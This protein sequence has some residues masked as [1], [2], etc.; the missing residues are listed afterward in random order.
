MP[1][2]CAHGDPDLAEMLA[3]PRVLDVLGP[4][5]AH[6]GKRPVKGAD[7][8]GDRDV[9]GVAVEAVGMGVGE[10]VGAASAWLVPIPTVRTAPAAPMAIA[11]RTARRTGVI[12]SDILLFS[13]CEVL[14]FDGHITSECLFPSKSIVKVFIDRTDVKFTRR[15]ACRE[16]FSRSMR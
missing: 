6:C 4:V 16:W 8:I 13:F 3:G 15:Q 11:C 12:D 14:G 9:A 1:H 5:P 7:D 2:C 10:G